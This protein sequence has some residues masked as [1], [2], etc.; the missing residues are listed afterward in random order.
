MYRRC[1]NHNC[2]NKGKLSLEEKSCSECGQETDVELAV[3]DVLTGY[4]PTHK[5]R[6]FRI[7]KQLSKPSDAGM[8]VVYLA[9]GVDDASRSGV[10]KVTKSR[11]RTALI[12][13]AGN[14]Q[15]LK[16]KNIIE[17]IYGQH[18]S[19]PEQAILTGKIDDEE[20]SFIGL[21]YLEG[22]SLKDKLSAKKQLPLELAAKVIFEIG[23][24]LDYAHQQRIV[25]LDIKPSNVLFSRG[26]QKAVLSDFGVTRQI[27]ELKEFPGHIGTPAYNAPEQRQKPPLHTPKADIYGLGLILYE[28]LV[29]QEVHKVRSSSSQEPGIN[30]STGSQPASSTPTKLIIDDLP[31]PRDLNPNIPPE[32]ERIILKAI[33]SEPADRYETVTKMVE[34]LKRVMPQKLAL[35][36]NVI[37]WLFLVIGGLTLLL[38]GSMILANQFPPGVETA[39]PTGENVIATETPASTIVIEFIPTE[40]PTPTPSP[41][42]TLTS[43]ASPTPPATSTPTFTP[44]PSPT[45]IPA[46]PTPPTIE[47]LEPAS[48][49]QIVGPTNVL[50]RWKW[51]DDCSLLRSNY[52]F[53]IRVWHHGSP[54]AGGAINSAVERETIMAGCNAGTYSYIM[55]DISS[56]PGVNNQRGQLAWYVVLVRLTDPP[57]ETGITSLTNVFIW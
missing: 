49:V 17:L 15:K 3:G 23:A 38:T 56:A 19:D 24:A 13:E 12:R 46:L 35:P 40:T 50:F 32:V 20:I 51:G 57:Q 55:G 25:H 22:G 8:S 9:E 42:H 26:G 45:P 39:V 11:Y 41:T 54:P 44:V 21:Q 52:S 31:A 14:L 2:S 16:H 28:M 36:R 4:T 27:E 10:L 30:K 43:P 1:S 6:R 7:K 34:E 37:R 53:Q 33:A 29:G 5:S 48:N 47:P 18:D